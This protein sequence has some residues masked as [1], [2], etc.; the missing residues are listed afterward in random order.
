MTFSPSAAVNAVVAAFCI[1]CAMAAPAPVWPTQFD[2][3]AAEWK[4]ALWA[5]GH[6]Y[7]TEHYVFLS[8]E[9]LGH[10]RLAG[11]ATT[12]EGVTAVLERFPVQLT[13][14]EGHRPPRG[15]GRGLP[16]GWRSMHLVHL[17]GTHAQYRAGG[18][19]EGSI[20]YYSAR[21]GR[22]LVSMERLLEAR[23]PRSNLEPRQRYRLL[24][25]EL[26]HQAMGERVGSLPLWLSEGLAEYFSAC[27]FAP[28][29]YRFD[30][31]PRSIAAQFQACWLG[32]RGRAATMPR[33]A[34]VLNFG[35]TAWAADNR[36]NPETSYAKYAAGL[37]LT[38]YQLELARRGRTELAEYLAAEPEFERVPGPGPPGR[39]RQVL[40]DTSALWDGREPASIERGLKAYWAERGL[41]LTFVDKLEAELPPFP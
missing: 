21:D 13:P 26:V 33:V 4:E 10:G 28:G 34:A 32:P 2:Q 3:P 6:A 11:I 27:Q 38:H 19:P 22:V 5:E 15:R 39:Y 20:G 16:A 17:Y 23:G 30:D 31:D 1:D 7:Q 18:G 12:A 36:M 29:R 40:P 24:V 35:H 9:P 41:D 37:L 8:A 25:H 14:V